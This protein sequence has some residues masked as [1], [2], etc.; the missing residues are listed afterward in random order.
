MFLALTST[1]FSYRL[2]QYDGYP[3]PPPPPTYMWQ[4]EPESCLCFVKSDGKHGTKVWSLGCCVLEMAT[5]SPPWVERRFDNIL[6]A[7]D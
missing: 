7:V 4:E 1:C 3:L 2:L 5:G 6:Q